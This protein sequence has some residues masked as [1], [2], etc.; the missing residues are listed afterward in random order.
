MAVD[1][2]SRL[3]RERMI[4][5]QLDDL[6]FVPSVRD[7]FTIGEHHFLVQEFMDGKP[8]NRALRRG[9]PLDGRAVDETELHEYV[10]WAVAVI[11]DVER[12]VASLRERGMIFGD[13]HMHNIIVRPDGTTSLIDF[14]VASFVGEG[15][16]PA[17]GHPGFHAPPDRTGFD[18]DR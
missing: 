1:A 5:T 8:L 15:R 16:R 6:D 7:Y 14:E 3:E 18:V 17:L 2:V 13:L 9:F 12:H 4:L 11:D 10:D